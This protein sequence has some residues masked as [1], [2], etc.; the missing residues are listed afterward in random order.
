[1]SRF[2][3]TSAHAKVEDLI[4]SVVTCARQLLR[5]CDP[6]RPVAKARDTLSVTSHS[7][8]VL[9]P[10]VALVSFALIA[11]THPNA[12][13][14]E[15]VSASS[16][17]TTVS[18]G[19]PGRRW[20]GAPIS[21]D[22]LTRSTGWIITNEPSH[23]LETTNGGDSWRS[24]GPVVAK[25]SPIELG[26]AFYLS[27]SHWW[28][29]GSDP[30]QPGRSVAYSTSNAGRTW[31]ASAQTFSY[32]V[33]APFFETPT[34]GWLEVSRPLGVGDDPATIYSTTDGGHAWKV[35]SRSTSFVPSGTTSGLPSGC[36]KGG[37]VFNSARSGWA[38]QSCAGSTGELEHTTDGGRDWTAVLLPPQPGE[39]SGGYS[40]SLPVFSS[41][42]RGAV[43]V[44]RGA[45]KVAI[46]TTTDGGAKWALRQS[47]TPLVSSAYTV[48][49]V[50]SPSIW[51]LQS[52]RTVEVTS[53][54]GLSWH[55]SIS[56]T[57]LVG[58]RVDFVTGRVGWAWTPSS[59]TSALLHTT[60][61]GGTWIAHSLTS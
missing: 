3:Y 39:H 53:H 15:Q 58:Y 4:R 17:R 22:F 23:L 20:T 29:I 19:Q 25:G 14:I 32:E 38:A 31:S 57:D 27:S 16:S 51:I 45:P 11:A 41:A 12:S 35:V 60:N 42:L 1:M 43:Y 54:S 2:V 6:R 34:L 50:V 28:V 46:Y 18:Q 5:D 56:N 52:N 55:R 47:P 36:S 30:H 49:D 26:G 21:V 59:T 61:G 8:G 10:S 44:V 33:L 13:R 7:R 9:R 37:L 40:A 24:V 48:V